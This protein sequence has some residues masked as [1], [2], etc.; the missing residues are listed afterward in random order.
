MYYERLLLKPENLG[1][2]YYMRQFS[3]SLILSSSDWKDRSRIVRLAETMRSQAHANVQRTVC[4][5]SRDR[6]LR[7]QVYE[8]AKKV[9]EGRSRAASSCIHTMNEIR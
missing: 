8:G 9:S 5:S 1:F 3:L 7:D 4:P 2:G 6:M